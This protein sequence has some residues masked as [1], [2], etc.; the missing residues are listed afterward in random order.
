MTPPA[1][2]PGVSP[3]AVSYATPR[4]TKAPTYSAIV[5]GATVLRIFSLVFFLGALLSLVIPVFTMLASRSM[6][7]IGLETVLLLLPALLTAA[8]LVASGLLIRLVAAVFLAIR[9]IAQNS[10]K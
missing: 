5:T 8:G 7:A 4:T 6:Q 2:V 9:D 1:V 3:M 10:Y